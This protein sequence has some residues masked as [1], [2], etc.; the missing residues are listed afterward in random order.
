[1]KLFSCSFS[2][3]DPVC[4]GSFFH[5]ASFVRYSS[6]SSGF[7]VV[8]FV[9]FIYRQIISKSAQTKERWR[10][11]RQCL[12]IG[13]ALS[14]LMRFLGTWETRWKLRTPARKPIDIHRAGFSTLKVGRPTRSRHHHPYLRYS[15]ERIDCTFV[16]C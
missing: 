15:R 11:L 10:A 2:T 6:L 5:C 14:R 8:S 13:A 12:A 7:I 4:L 9:V 1:M 3:S 16:H